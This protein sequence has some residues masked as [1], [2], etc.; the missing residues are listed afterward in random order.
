MA[1]LDRLARRLNRPASARNLPHLI[2]VFD[3]ARSGD[4]RRLAKRLPRGAALLYRHFGDPQRDAT[5]RDLVRIARRRGAWVWVSGL[6]ARRR[7][8]PPRGVRLVHW[9]ER[10]RAR[11][12]RRGVAIG[13]AA[14]GLRG[15]MRAQRQRVDVALLSTAFASRSPSAGR[16]IGAIRLRLLAMRSRVAV[17]ALGGITPA[18]ARRL[19]GARLAGFAAVDAVT[20]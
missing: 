17:Y 18:T 4:P 16:P 6:H 8:A 1:R 2:A 12:W 11:A 9:P 13:Q 5:V 3:P 19:A 15:V 10:R 14:H 20:V 7:W